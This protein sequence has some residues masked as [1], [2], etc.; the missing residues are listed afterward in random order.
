MSVGFVVKG[1][2]DAKR[3]YER[4]PDL[5]NEAA[6]FA[7]NDTLRDEEVAVRRDME[8]QINF[9]KGYLRKSDRYGIGKRATKG[10]LEGRLYGRDRPTSLA[11]FAGGATRENSRGRSIFVRVS[12]TG[13]TVELK[14]A[15][16]IQLR[17][18]NL[19]LAIR[20]PE[21]QSPDRAYKPVQLTQNN[22]KKLLPIWLLYGPSVDQVMSGVITGRT[23]EIQDALSRNFDRQLRRLTSRG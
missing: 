1:L 22:G 5:V 23:N 14:R 11:R 2:E 21:G 4:M 16:I 20:L 15:F 19:G 12:K 7:V 3:L 8:T 10:S 18:G 9:P 17:N 13:G 6:Y